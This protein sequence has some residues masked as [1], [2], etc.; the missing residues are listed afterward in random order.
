MKEKRECVGGF[1][2]VYDIYRESV[3]ACARVGKEAKHWLTL[4]SSQRKKTTQLRE[5]EREIYT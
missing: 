5:R 3:R 2:C 4:F 1:Q